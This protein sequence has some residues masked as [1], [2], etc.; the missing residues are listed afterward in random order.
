MDSVSD[1]ASG[2][3]THE[4]INASSGLVSF[5]ATPPTPVTA[6]S[7]PNTTPMHDVPI[8]THFCSSCKK[9]IP[10]EA[11]Q[12]R[13]NGSLYNTCTV[14][15]TRTKQR[16][17]HHGQQRVTTPTGTA[18]PRG[19]TRMSSDSRNQQITTSS[20]LTPSSAPVPTPVSLAPAMPGNSDDSIRNVLEN[21][22]ERRIISS[23]FPYCSVADDLD[24]IAS[25]YDTSLLTTIPPSLPLLAPV[26]PPIAFPRGSQSPMRQPIPPA[27]STTASS[28]ILPTQPTIASLG[29]RQCTSSV[30]H[31]SEPPPNKRRR[32][33]SITPSASNLMT[34]DAFVQL[35]HQRLELERQR[36]A[37]DQERWREERAERLRWEQ[38][39]RE[40]WQE[41]REQRKVFRE[42]EQ[43]IWRILLSLKSLSE[44][45]M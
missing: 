16:K 43:H 42:R 14:C 23:N 41:E 40:Q 9:R 8:S 18:E 38:M 44:T 28:S 32:S 39:Y 4:H 15:L 19:T 25:S 17:S 3:L 20:A 34:P 30:G 36:L 26:R 31:A 33:D 29:T 45:N 12:R 5:T 37:L 6:T 24:R 35:E 11:F 7:Q 13:Q 2:L 22:A 1:L 21:T 27:I 10:F